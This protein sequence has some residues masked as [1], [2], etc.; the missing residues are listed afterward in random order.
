LSARRNGRAWAINATDNSTLDNVTDDRDVLDLSGYQAASGAY[1]EMRAPDGSVRSAWQRFLDVSRGIDLEELEERRQQAQRLLQDN[2]VTYNVYGDPKGVER[3]WAFDPIPAIIPAEE[4][5]EVEIGLR[6]R[7]YLL[8]LILADL[9]GPQRLLYD[10]LLPPE[11]VFANPKFL[12]PCHGGASQKYGMLTLLATDLAR[13]PDGRWVALSDWTQAPSGAGYALENRIVMSR[14]FPSLVR[15]CQVER[16]AM[17]FETLRASLRAMA[18]HNRDQPNIVLLTPGPYN[19]TYFEHVYL[20]RYLGFTLVEG[21]DLTVRDNRVYLK[22]LGGLQQVDVILRRVDDEFCDPLELRTDSALGVAGLTQ[23][24]LSGNVAIANG[25]GAGLVETQALAA[26][27]PK[28]C[29]YFLNEELRLAPLPAWWCA[30]PEQRAH[31]EEHLPDLALGLAFANVPRPGYTPENRAAATEMQR[32][33]IRARPYAYVGRPA[34]T[35]STIP[36]LSNGQLE[37]R[38]LIVRAYTIFAGP[39]QQFVL[40]GGLTRFA[41]SHVLSEVSMQQGSGSKDTWICADRPVSPYSLLPLPG[42]RLDLKRASNDLP[43]RTADN[44]YW[45]GRYAERVEGTARILRFLLGRL[46]EE[47]GLQQNDGLLR[48]VNA[49]PSLALSNGDPLD[50]KTISPYTL[51][52]NLLAA[53][54]DPDEPDSV[55]W[56][57]RALQQVGWVVRDRLSSDSWRILNTLNKMLGDSDAIVREHDLGSAHLALNRLLSGLASYAGLANEN[58]TRGP[59]WRFL[60]LGKRVERALTTVNLIESALLEPI[61]PE[62]ALLQAILEVF[63]SIMTYRSR[64]SVNMDAAAVLDLLLCDE[65][66]PRSAGFQVHQIVRHLERLP[67]TQANAGLTAEERVATRMLSE[68]RLSDAHLLAEISPEGL[69]EQLGALLRLTQKGI[70]DFSDA[71]T[72]RYFSHTLPARQLESLPPG[73]RA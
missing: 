4:W 33:Q 73:S 1:D 57:L 29:R 17:F 36:V 18:P 6:Q 48:L 2:G 31:V 63:D 40:P 13:A 8:N 20:A 44:I 43:S 25:L 15:D 14:L 56:T 12:R 21:E 67:K 70:P 30:D 38:Y 24:M 64:Y 50:A 34:P 23:A 58:M 3:P 62:E 68:I 28:L 69:R 71:L 52:R 32:E 10:G 72:R 41:P 16:L 26:Y 53:I 61:E 42:Q 37:S 47:A 49:V 19:E 65:S 27:L 54:Y 35:L 9:Y 39:D 66:N 45:L 55:T 59:G 22:T 51:E 11:F 46:T 60:D 7:A 5:A